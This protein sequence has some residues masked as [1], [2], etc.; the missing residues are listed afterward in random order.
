MI[1]RTKF[2]KFRS[3]YDVIECLLYTDTHEGI[4]EMLAESH[5]LELSL[6]TLGSYLCRY[7]KQ[8]KK[9]SVVIDNPFIR[10][11]T[12]QGLDDSKSSELMK[13]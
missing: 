4:V 12:K 8:S 5:D 9:L 11:E 6:S 2:L 13:Q 1:K 3:L 7:K 10:A